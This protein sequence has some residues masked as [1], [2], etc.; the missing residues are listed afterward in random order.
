MAKSPAHKLGQIIGDEIEAAVG[1]PLRD[2]AAKFGLYLDHQHPRPTRR[3]RRKVAW[4]D[5]YGNTHDLDYVL[6]EGG[7]EENQGHPRAFVEIAWRRY[8]KHSRNKVQEIQ[9]AVLPL[10][11]TYREHAPFLGVVLAGD[12]TEGSRDQLQSH[13][14]HVAYVSYEMVVQAF[15]SVGVDLAFDERTSATELRQRV[16]AHNHLTAGSRERLGTEIRTICAVELDP[17]F[18][19]L[20][21]SLGRRITHIVVLALSGTS[22]RFQTTHEAIRFIENYDESVPAS[23]FD[24]YELNV[25]YSNGSEVRGSFLD[26]KDCLDHLRLLQSA[27]SA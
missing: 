27:Q 23:E 13:G 26:K 19:S 11:E 14:F 24:R 9:S 2:L 18:N 10:A 20:R 22:A 12:F 5:S 17:F 1:R 21:D 15:L 8:T 4:Q 25:R 7:N 16:R 3:G 6:E